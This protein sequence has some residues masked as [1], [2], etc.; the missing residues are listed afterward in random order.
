MTISNSV[1][2]SPGSS[3]V[4]GVFTAPELKTEASRIDSK[5]THRLAHIYTKNSIPKGPS[6]KKNT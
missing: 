6:G 3:T 1:W 4:P 2:F 5:R